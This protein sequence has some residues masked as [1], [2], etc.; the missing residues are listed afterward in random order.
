LPN[1]QSQYFKKLVNT[2]YI[3]AV[4]VQL[5]HNIFRLLGFFDASE[6][7]LLILTHEFAKKAQKTPPPE[8]QTATKRK[9]EH[10]S[11]KKEEK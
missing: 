8:I 2:E 10:L 9:H 1:A 6:K 4:R 3:W 11:R 5:G 7:N